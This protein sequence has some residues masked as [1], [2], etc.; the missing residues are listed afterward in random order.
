[1]R[2]LFSTILLC[3]SV[4]TS[5][6]TL[7]EVVVFGDSLSDNGNLYEYMKHRF[8]VCPPYYKGRMTNGPVWAELLVDSYF[9]GA[10]DKHLLDYAYAGAAVASEDDDEPLFTLNSELQSYFLSHQEKANDHTLYVVW[11]GA[12]NYL[13][14]PE[15]ADKTVQDVADGIK[16]SL[17][18]LADKGAKHVLVLNLP[19]LGRTP[20]AA[21]IGATTE[22]TAFSERH[23][24]LLFDMVSELQSTHPGVQWLHFDV[25]NALDDLLTNPT[26]NGFSNITGTCYESSIDEPSSE[27]DLQVASALKLNSKKSACDGYLFFD[28]VHPSALAHQIL[29]TRTHKLLD[30]SGITFASTAE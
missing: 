25:R 4:V 16:R 17:K 14:L 18:Q 26:A 10:V 7:D 1:M 29:A 22:L 12:N 5:A 19:D 20:A 30:D 11:I 28:P 23:N 2:I 3:L 24:Q 15:N 27:L 21:D 9:P 6:A 8:P 13:G